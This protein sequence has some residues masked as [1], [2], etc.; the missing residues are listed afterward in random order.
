MKKKTKILKEQFTVRIYNIED[1]EI[2]DKA[3]QRNKTSFDNISEFTRYCL[4]KGAKQLLDENEIDHTKSLDEIT[5]EL[6]KINLKLLFIESE[7]KFNH[8]DLMIEIQLAEKLANYNA[9]ILCRTNYNKSYVDDV[10]NGLLDL[11][12]EKE[13]IKLERS[14]N[15]LQ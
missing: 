11:E 13:K 2:I 3:Y 8:R 6:N 5:D 4:V 10:N 9:N 7:Q 1:K 15:E 12:Y 14:R